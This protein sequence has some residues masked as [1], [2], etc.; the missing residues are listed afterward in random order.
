MEDAESMSGL[1][2]V[3]DLYSNGEDK[4][5]SCRSAGDELIERLARHVLHDDVP[6]VAGFAHFV[7]GADVGVLDGRSKASLAKNGGA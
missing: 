4:L 2:P 7:N 6:L 1:K 3:G 5:R